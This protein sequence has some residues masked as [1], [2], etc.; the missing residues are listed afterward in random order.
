MCAI[1]EISVVF[2]TFETQFPIFFGY[3]DS[4]HKGRTHALWLGS[5]S[6]ETVLQCGMN[7]F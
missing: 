7:D 2:G 3:P 1:A 6:R 5:S 4:V